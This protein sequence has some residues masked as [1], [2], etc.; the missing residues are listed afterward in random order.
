[1]LNKVTSFQRVYNRKSFKKIKGIALQWGNLTNITSSQMIKV[2]GNNDSH[3]DSTSFDMVDKNGINPSVSL[4]EI[5]NSSLI[6]RK[7]SDKLQLRIPKNTLVVLFKTFEMTKIR[8]V[9]ETNQRRT[10]SLKG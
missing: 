1:M 2:N 6:F 4:P 10:K 7:T 8:K 9:W 5:H 3:V